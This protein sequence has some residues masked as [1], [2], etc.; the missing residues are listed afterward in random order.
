LKG[1]RDEISTLWMIPIE[2]Q[3]K[4]NLLA[5]QLPSV[6]STHAANSA[7][8][9]PTIAKLMAYLNATI[10]SLLVKTLCHAINN[11][12][13]TSF[14]GL[15]SKAI[16]KHLPKSIST[17]MGHM[18]MIRKGIRSTTKPTIIEIMN[19]ELEKEPEL[20][21]PQQITNRQHTVGVTTMNFEKLK[22]IIATDLPGRFPTTLGQGNAY[23]LVMYDYDS[24]SIIEKQHH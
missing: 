1:I 8:H 22:G 4:M 21:L 23:V 7:Y 19:E 3:K 6:P 18:H 20:D 11:D 5:Q 16:K 12:W 9:Q 13:P 24:N 2:H 17:T 10:G 15:T 14:P